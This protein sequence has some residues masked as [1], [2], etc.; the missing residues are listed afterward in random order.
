MKTKI[1][2]L[3][4]TL[5][6]SGG[7]Q[8]ADSAGGVPVTIDNFVRA[9]SDLYFGNVIKEG[10]F[11]KFNHNR[12]PASIENQTVIR[13]NRDT[14]YSSAVFDLDAGPVTITLPDAGKRYMAMQ[15]ITEE[16]YTPMVVHGAGSTTLKY[17][18][19]G[20]RYVMAA[21][22][23]LV[24]PADPKDVK[25]VHALQNA[26]KV[27][28]AKVGKF[29]APNWDLAS[30][31]KVRDALLTLASTVSGFRGAFGVK[32]VVDPV[33]RL[34]GAAAGWGG[35]PDKEAVYFGFTPSMNDGVTV[36]KTV[37]KDV[38]VDAF[39][40]VSVYNAAGYFEPNKYN[41]YSLNNITAK[42]GTDGSVTVQFGGCDGKIPNCIPT[43]KGW[44][45]LVRLYQPRAEILNGS[46]KFPE[47]QPVGSN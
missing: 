36:Y 26:I 18:E 10:G 8:A 17:E 6:L 33:R 29:E 5:G 21:V 38:P 39:W 31:K 12:M 41:S 11:G 27:K 16:H 32:G 2:A 46:W 15:I 14:L 19:L 9:E 23:T 35:N 47:A 13:L 4:L 22:R 43:M 7:I 34:L 24:N 25:K 44:N 28:Q 45:Y 1:I 3:V 42:K 37:V 40:S 30:Q 20:S